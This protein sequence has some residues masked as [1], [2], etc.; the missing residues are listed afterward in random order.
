MLGC[1]EL[2]TPTRPA[3][4]SPESIADTRLGCRCCLRDRIRSVRRGVSAR[5]DARRGALLRRRSVAGEY[6]LV[7]GGGG[8]LV[9]LTLEEVEQRLFG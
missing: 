8:V 4:R 9:D 6:G 3:P 7:V 5:R 1:V 2:W